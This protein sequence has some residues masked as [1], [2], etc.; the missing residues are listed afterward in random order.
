MLERLQDPPDHALALKASG[1]VM[2]R[3]VEAAVDAALGSPTAPTGV[4]V[5]IDHDF[6]GYLAE[7]ARGLANVALGHKNVVRMAVVMEPYLLAEAKLNAWTASPVPI[8]LFAL[9][10]RAAAY[11]WADAARRGE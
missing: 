3:D 8:R 11:N 9:D 1:T 7:L 6:D 2:A 4:V 10:E 5:V